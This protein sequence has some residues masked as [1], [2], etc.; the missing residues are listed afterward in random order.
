MI[1]PQDGRGDAEPKPASGFP[2]DLE[3]EY[4][5]DLFWGSLPGDPSDYG[6]K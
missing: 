2:R 5:E 1:D 4:E 6:D 3:E